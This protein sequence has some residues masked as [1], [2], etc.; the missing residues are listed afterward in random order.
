MAESSKIPEQAKHSSDL[1]DQLGSLS[2][3]SSKAGRSDKDSP[4]LSETLNVEVLSSKSSSGKDNKSSTSGEDLSSESISEQG[5]QLS[6]PDEDVKKFISLEDVAAHIALDSTKNVVVI[7]GAGIST[8]SGI[9]DFR[10][11]GTGLYDNLQKYD[12]PFPEAIFVLQYFVSNPKPF[13]TL[14]KELYPDKYK[15]NIA[16]YFVKLLENEGKLLHMFTQNIDGLER[17]VGIPEN[18]LIEAHGTV[19]TAT[20]LK[21]RHKYTTTDTFI[22]DAIFGDKIP[23]CSQSKCKGIL[24]PDIVFFGENL[25]D[26]FWNF[27]HIMPKADMIVVLGTS[28]EVEPFASIVDYCS[29]NTPR[30]LINNEVVGSFKYGGGSDFLQIGDLSDGLRKL[31]K[32]LNWDEKLSALS[33]QS[34]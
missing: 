17:M 16:H 25:P 18:K 33:K 31:I 27:K 29:V 34:V 6:T 1:V 15:P 20:C 7:A 28:L 23:K 32:H 24:K 10:S 12:L 30:L 2:L 4:D 9:P 21:C 22:K 5:D 26:K 11:P 19:T 8:A 14:A 3:D 13:Y